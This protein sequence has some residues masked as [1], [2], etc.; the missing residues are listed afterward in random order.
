MRHLKVLSTTAIAALALVVGLTACGSS[1]GDSEGAAK[2]TTTVAK[3][4]GDDSTTTADSSDDGGDDASTT[5]VATGGGEFCDDLASYMNETAMDDVDVTDPASYK[6]A[7]EEST[8]RGKALLSEA[9]SELDDS[10]EVI[11]DAQDRLIAALEKVDYDFTKLP[12]DALG[13]MS[14]PEVE[15]AGKKL[16]AYVTDTCGI[17]IPQVTAATIPDMTTMTVPN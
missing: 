4:S 2:S 6:K 14:T 3:G 13:A 5:V 15:A 16:D 17:D 9:P 10:V 12:T 7:I 1:G 8:K 11:L